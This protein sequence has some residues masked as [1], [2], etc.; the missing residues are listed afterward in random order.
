MTRGASLLLTACRAALWALAL[1]CAL[2]F[3]SY[4]FYAATDSAQTAQLGALATA[5]APLTGTDALAICCT[6]L[7][8]L[9]AALLTLCLRQLPA[10]GSI[11]QRTT[12]LAQRVSAARRRARAGRACP[13]CGR[14]G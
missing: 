1:A 9:A 13:A 7:S 3:L 4:L 14:W 5:W 11:S 12:G 6:W 2:A 8:L 10:H